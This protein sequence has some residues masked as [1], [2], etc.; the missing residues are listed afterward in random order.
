MDILLINNE[1]IILLE[2]LLQHIYSKSQ[3][4]H[5]RLMTYLF[6]TSS[7]TLPFITQLQP[8]VHVL[9]K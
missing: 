4:K 8:R 1:R 5:F 2:T 6:S 7:T 9:M 3:A